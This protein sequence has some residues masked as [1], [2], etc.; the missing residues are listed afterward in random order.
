[1]PKVSQLN[2]LYP[3]D[4]NVLRSVREEHSNWVWFH[5]SGYIQYCA[6]DWKTKVYEHR[7]VAERT[8]HVRL[9]RGTQV[10]HKNAVRNDNRAQNL[11]IVNAAEHVLFHQGQ[12][13]KITKCHFCG[14]EFSR[15]V[16]YITKSAK[17]YCNTQC[18]HNGSRLVKRPSKQT[19]EKLIL[20]HKNFCFIGRIYGV[21]DNTIRDWA[22]VYGLPCKTRKIKS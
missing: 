13:R 18:L 12:T 19:L 3:T 2:M 9:N 5:Q 10:H 16:S 17:N 15:Q 14:K 8:F 21:S 11:Q 7:L 1:M 4:C 22:K 6:P 20:E